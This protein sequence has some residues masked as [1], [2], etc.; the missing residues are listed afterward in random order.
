MSGRWRARIIPADQLDLASVATR[1]S[2]PLVRAEALRRL[3]NPTAQDVLL[4][5]IESDDPFLQQAA[6]QGWRR[7]LTMGDLVALVRE[8]GLAALQRLA[9]LLVMRDSNSVEA[10]SLVPDFL[11]SPDPRIR[12]AAIQWVG[13]QRLKEF[14]P[15][16]LQGLVSGSATRAVFEATLAA[17][18]RLDGKKSRPTR[19]A[20]G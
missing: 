5:A 9:V 3:A 12:F 13:E 7:S 17:F 14:R 8:P 15:Q 2:S 1:D 11:A 16:L 20:G 18:E 10:R 4:K 6:R 19:R